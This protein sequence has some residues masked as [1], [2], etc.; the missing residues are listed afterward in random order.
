[1]TLLSRR[2]TVSTLAVT[3]V[4]AG[5][6][7]R[8]G[9][10]PE[11]SPA[12]PARIAVNQLGFLPA[13][14]KWAVVT[15]GVGD[16]FEVRRA[17]NG[18]VV[19]QG[20]LGPAAEWAPAEQTGRLADFSALQ[21]PGEYRLQVEGGE[22]SV[23]F[24]ISPTAYAALNAATLKAYYYNRSGI[25]LL[26]EHAGAWARPAGHPDTVV[27][28]H[29]SAASP[30]R[31][32]GTLISSPKGW[33]DAGDYNKYIV[34][35]GI[36]V[37]TLLAAYEHFPAWFTAQRLNIPESGNALPDVLDEALWN[38]DWMLSMQDPDDGGIYHKLTDL[39]FDGTRMP[40]EAKDDRYVVQKS[41][42]ATLDFAA[43][44]AMASRVYQP[45]EAQRPGLSAR[46]LAAAQRAWQWAQA[47]QNEIYRQPADVVTGEYGDGGV[48]DEFAW[49]AA[50]LYISTRDDDYWRALHA[51]RLTIVV[52][53]W[54]DVKGLAWVSLAQHRQQL[55]PAADQ[56]LITARI[57]SL[58]TELAATWKASSYRLSMQRAD[59]VWGSN[60][61]A[62]NQALMLVQG[63]RL[64][65]QRDQLDAAQ[66]VLDYVLGRNPLG[67]SMVTGFGARSPLHPHHRPS[68]ADGVD[69]PV[70]G[71]IVAGPN[72][73][74]Q[75]LVHCNAV[76]PSK[77]PA[78]SYVD[79]YCSYASNEV[80]I[81]WNAPLVYLS[82]AMQ[83]LTGTAR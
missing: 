23:P 61:V 17:D 32:E 70:P 44:M 79:A 82:A 80:A 46:M 20:R 13:S 27:K 63:Y 59:Y 56:A 21:T 41:T 75:D 34:N 2:L 65:G 74:Q 72:P 3:L 31:P 5:C 10:A 42:A 36:S 62:L 26:P 51:D 53:G 18:A 15:G 78:R 68:G 83:A 12:E 64:S 37:Y 11:G 77:A 50:E 71:F 30:S 55:T 76:Y 81:N 73:G 33:Y 14:A 52:P 43:V 6:A 24:A 9:L 67:L 29:A 66:S 58:A 25:A 69:A 39:R 40:H 48:A 45:F 35:S 28:V 38:L 54:G 7:S 19:H 4:L 8:P 47:H 16:R 1:M 49:A 60:A 57:N 22:P